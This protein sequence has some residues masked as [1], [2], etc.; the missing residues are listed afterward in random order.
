[1]APQQALLD[2]ELTFS[3]PPFSTL[4]DARLLRALADLKFAHPTLVQAKAI[5]LLLE[6]KDVLARART[7]SG[8]TAAYVVPAVQRVLEAKAAQDPTSPTYQA[9]RALVLVPTRELAMQVA[10]FVKAL[11]VYAEGLVSVVNAAGSANVQ[12]VL[13]NDNPD[14][15]VATP[16]KLLALLQAKSVDLSHLLFL[17]IDEADL[18]LSYGHKDDLTRI[19]DPA[20]NFVPRLGLQAC[21]MSATLSDDVSSIKGLVL[22]NPAI[23][24]L[25]EPATS[26]SLLTQH[27]TYTSE[28]DKF[29]LIFVLLKLKL[30]KGKSIIFVNDIERG[31]RLRLFLEHFGIKCC[32]VNSELPLASRYHV[33]EEFNRGVYDVV[34]ATDEATPDDVEETAEEETAEEEAA[35]EEEAE[36]DAEDDKEEED[37]ETDEEEKEAVST[38]AEAGPSKRRATSPPAGAQRKKKRGPGNSMARGIDFTAASSVINFDLPT[39]ATAYLHRVGR[40]ARA[41][42]SGLALSFVVPKDKWGKD[43]GVSLKTAKLDDEVFGKI[44]ARVK[45]ESGAEIKEWDWGGRRGEIEG[46]RYRMEDALRAV[47][48]KRVQDARREEVRRELLNSEKLKQHFAANPLDLAF[49]RHDAPLHAGR[50]S[51]HLKHVPGYLM[52][53]IA[54]LPTGGDV[55]D[56]RHI[57][58]AKRGRGGRAGRGGRGGR[59]GKGRKVDPLKFKG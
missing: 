40:T 33:V 30:I 53:K 45:T 4:L 9:T 15:V 29:L 39:T 1:M 11:T 56:G 12:R 44:K 51:R 59:G 10:A 41:G 2:S 50:T 31:Y 32:V 26:S 28:R 35:E 7:G 27:F 17:A 46:F 43:K 58:F 20:M 54:A 22:R 55:G 23:L 8:K 36:E 52:P 16:S 42:H 21:L 49:L 19:L 25:S 6:G 3:S 5:P 13:L 18:L 57:P 37:E 47:T 24:T 34:I 14:V 38:N 48:S